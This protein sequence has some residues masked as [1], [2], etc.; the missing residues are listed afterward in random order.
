MLLKSATIKQK[1]VKGSV[2]ASG[3][4]RISRGSVCRHERILFWKFRQIAG[5][6]PRDAIRR[7]REPNYVRR[8]YAVVDWRWNTTEKKIILFDG[9]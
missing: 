6:A 1:P 8:D 4:S 5:K 3:Y 2:R 9:G 7:I